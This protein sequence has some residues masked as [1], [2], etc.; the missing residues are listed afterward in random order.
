[1]ESALRSEA[2]RALALF[3]LASVVRRGVEAAQRALG[4]RLV[5]ARSLMGLRLG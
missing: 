4:G 1:M 2:A 3:A 5:R